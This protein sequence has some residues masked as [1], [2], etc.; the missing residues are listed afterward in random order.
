M[1]GVVRLGLTHTRGSYRLVAELFNLPLTDYKRFL[2]FLQKYDCHMAF[3]HFRLISPRD[4]G[5]AASPSTA[6]VS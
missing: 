6:K 3:Q 4:R 1:R 5:P 2:N